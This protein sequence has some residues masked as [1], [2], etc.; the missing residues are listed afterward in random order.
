[1]AENKEL[2]IADRLKELEARE[3]AIAAKETEV[4]E[5][6]RKAEERLKAMEAAERESEGQLIRPSEKATL[7]P[8]PYRFL[9]GPKNEKYKDVLKSKEI[10]AID[11]TEAIRVYILQTAHPEKAGKQ[12]DPLIYE[13][14]A[15]NLE[16]EKREALHKKAKRL[17]L[18]RAKFDKGNPLTDE[19]ET[20]LREADYS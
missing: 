8:N 7:G 9:V 20:L 19:E 1:M 4:A 12:V 6:E 17:E 14:K 10:S 18:I 15:V 16:P 11:E 2:T 5:K 3:K 13:L